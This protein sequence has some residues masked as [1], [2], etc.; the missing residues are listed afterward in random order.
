M[1]HLLDLVHLNSEE[2]ANLGLTYTPGEILQQ[3][4][5]WA[6]TFQNFKEHRAAIEAFLQSA[7]V[8]PGSST[9]PRLR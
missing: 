1:T 2:K 3:P 6:I 7:G 8:T 9:H 4:Q 5:T